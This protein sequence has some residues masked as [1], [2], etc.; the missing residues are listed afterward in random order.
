L[1][2]KAKYPRAPREDWIAAEKHIARLVLD[3]GATWEALTAGVERYAAYCRATGRIVANPANWFGAAD[4]P[5]LQSWALPEP[6]QRPQRGGLAVDPE[7][8]A[9]RPEAVNA[10]R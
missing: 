10:G 2:L 4:R 1:L 6:A 5:W 8:W 9:S 7:E 3:A